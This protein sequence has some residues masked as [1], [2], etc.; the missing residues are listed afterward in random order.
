M[1]PTWSS[2]LRGLRS[3]RSLVPSGDVP[4]FCAARRPGWNRIIPGHCRIS[5]LS[6]DHSTV[7]E[8]GHWFLSFNINMH[9]WSNVCIYIYIYSHMSGSYC[10]WLKKRCLFLYWYASMS[11]RILVIKHVMYRHVCVC[12]SINYKSISMQYIYI[13]QHVYYIY[14]RKHRYVRHHASTVFGTWLQTCMCLLNI[15]GGQTLKSQNANPCHPTRLLLWA[16]T[17]SRANGSIVC[18]LIPAYSSYKMCLN[19][20]PFQPL[21]QQWHDFDYLNVRLCTKWSNRTAVCTVLPVDLYSPR[22]AFPGTSC[23]SATPPSAIRSAWLV[24]QR[25]R[26]QSQSHRRQKSSKWF[27]P[28]LTAI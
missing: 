1:D 3:L 25:C 14:I 16:N 2:T 21:W 12:V 20:C 28:R 6:T 4:M 8:W 15:T 13:Y 23:A 17:T 27:I 19:G 5:A 24:A 18:K 7:G 9:F 11:T 10:I 26:R 22:G